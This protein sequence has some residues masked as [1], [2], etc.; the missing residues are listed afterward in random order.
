MNIWLIVCVRVLFLPPFYHHSTTHIFLSVIF[1]NISLIHIN[2][3]FSGNQIPTT[4][5]KWIADE[6]FQQQVGKY[7]LLFSVFYQSSYKLCLQFNT[8]Y[9]M[10]LLSYAYIFLED[11]YYLCLKGYLNNYNIRIS[12]LCMHDMSH[13]FNT[14]L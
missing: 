13:D 14:K 12:C 3:C 2:W 9:C 11:N 1:G 7:I 4:F 10:H 5:I 8:P 6:V